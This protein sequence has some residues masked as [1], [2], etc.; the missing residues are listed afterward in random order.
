MFL[1]IKKEIHSKKMETIEIF[2]ASDQ[3]TTCPKCG[4]RTNIIEDKSFTQKHLC[5]NETCNYQF[6][7]EFDEVKSE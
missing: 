5:L 3:P 7:L 6:I 2:L 1:S 4:V